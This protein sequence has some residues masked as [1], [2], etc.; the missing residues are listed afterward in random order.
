M[1]QP[2]SVVGTFHL[3][4]VR[5]FCAHSDHREALDSSYSGVQLGSH[6]PVDATPC[7]GLLDDDRGKVRG[8]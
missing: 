3:R 2:N 5:W 1:V 4:A 6:E 8:S 7:D